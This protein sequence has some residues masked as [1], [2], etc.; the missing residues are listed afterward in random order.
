MPS[1]SPP[2]NPEERL[3]AHLKQAL[4]KRLTVRTKAKL[5]AAAIE[6]MAMLEKSPARVMAYFQDKRVRYAA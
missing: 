5:R 6:H 3:D 4:G 2:L 1:Y